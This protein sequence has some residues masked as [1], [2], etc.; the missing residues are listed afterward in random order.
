MKSLIREVI[1]YGLY[2]GWE[3]KEGLIRE[4]GLSTEGSL[5][6]VVLYYPIVS[7]RFLA[8]FVCSLVVDCSN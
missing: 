4:V 5:K 3:F 8:A 6:E 2:S 7:F 1:L